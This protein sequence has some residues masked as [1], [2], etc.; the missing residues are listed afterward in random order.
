MLQ[1]FS[2][3]LHF[4][5]ETFTLFNKQIFFIFIACSAVEFGA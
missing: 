1:Y 3:T 2:V 5:S 4:S